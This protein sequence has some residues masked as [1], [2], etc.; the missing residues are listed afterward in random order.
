MGLDV[1]RAYKLYANKKSDLKDIVSIFDSGPD[2]EPCTVEEH[3][4]FH[5]DWLLSIG[6]DPNREFYPWKSLFASQPFRTTVLFFNKKIFK[7]QK[8]VPKV[9]NVKQ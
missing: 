6:I 1:G 5:K 2:V 8:S 7:R 3:A 9:Q 4:K